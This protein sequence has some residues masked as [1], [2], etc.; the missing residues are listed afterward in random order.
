MALSII[1]IAGILCSAAVLISMKK[2]GHFFKSAFLCAV[3]GI[4]ALFAVNAAGA[5]TGVT[6]S[7]NPLTIASGAIFGTP[8]IIFHLM[9]KI[10]VN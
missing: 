9:A 2:S 10:I 4:A 1:Y 8:G 7:V 5:L 3:Q 6:L